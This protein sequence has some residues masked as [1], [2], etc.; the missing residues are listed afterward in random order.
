MRVVLQQLALGFWEGHFT[1]TPS[2]CLASADVSN[3]GH[4]LDSEHPVEPLLVLAAFKLHTGNAFASNREKK[5]NGMHISK[6]QG[7][8]QQISNERW[9]QLVAG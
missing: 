9:V 7:F 5:S 1:R 6:V 3:L 8:I 4:S 2:P